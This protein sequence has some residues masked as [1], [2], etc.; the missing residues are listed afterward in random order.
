MRNLEVATR[1]SAIVKTLRPPIRAID[2]KLSP[3]RAAELR[4]AAD[5]AIAEL[6]ALASRL[7]KAKKTVTS[8]KRQQSEN[9]AA[10]PKT[11]GAS[12]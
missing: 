7:A 3:A 8:S 11:R 12:L 1:I 2:A 10:L 6:D 5:A 9:A 4:R